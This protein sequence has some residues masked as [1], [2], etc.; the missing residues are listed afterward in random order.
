ML[1]EI[2]YRVKNNMMIMYSLLNLQSSGFEDPEMVEQFLK[3]P[4]RI[5]SMVL[6]H[7]KLYESKNLSKIS[8]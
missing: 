8:F 2:H 6:V 4:N 7:E 1:K 3:A 5:E